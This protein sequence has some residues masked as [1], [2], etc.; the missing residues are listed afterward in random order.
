VFASEPPAL[1]NPLLNLPGVPI[2]VTPHMGSRTECG[3]RAMHEGAADQ[4][5]QVLRGER[6]DFLVNPEVWPGRMAPVVS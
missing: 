6:P 5:L 1:D 4:V 2:V 3:V